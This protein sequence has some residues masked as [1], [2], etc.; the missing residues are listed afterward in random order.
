MLDHFLPDT[1]DSLKTFFTQRQL[2][3]C[4]QNE[5]NIW[6]SILSNTPDLY[7]VDKERIQNYLGEAPFTQDMPHEE[8]P[9]NI[10]QWV[11]WQIVKK[12][13]SE[14]PQTDFRQLLQTPAKKIFQEARYKPK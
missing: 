12:Y 14:H 6:G 3:W 9:G 1:P 11:G 13:A 8:S 5:G 7:T 4:R 2:D 10:G